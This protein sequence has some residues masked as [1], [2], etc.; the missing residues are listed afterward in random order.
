MIEQHG[1]LN[2]RTG[3]IGSAVSSYFTLIASITVTIV[4]AAH[5]AAAEDPTVPVLPPESNPTPTQPNA[6][7]P[8][9][10]EPII[11]DN[12]DAHQAAERRAALRVE[13]KARLEEAKQAFKRGEYERTQE[14]ARMVLLA[15]PRNVLAAEWL[16]TAQGKLM[17]AD[18]KVTAVASDRRD[19]EAILEV[20][21]HAVRP[22]PRLPTERPHFP[23]RNE[24]KSTARQ[25][26]ISEKLDKPLPL[27]SFTDAPLDYVLDI[28]FKLTDVNIIADPAALQDKKLTIL[29]KD[30]PLKQ[31]L[32]FIVRNNE[33][34][35]YS[36]TEDAVWIT[37]TDEKD[38]KKIMYPRIYPLHF[39]LVSTTEG[40]GS[41]IGSGASSGS[42]GSR[43]ARPAPAVGANAQELSYLETI[44]KWLKDQ[45]KDAQTFPEGSDYLVDRQS[46]Q[47]IVYTTPSGH[48]HINEFLDAFDQPAIQVL[49]KARFLDI[50]AENNKSIGLNLDNLATPL[51]NDKVV[52]PAAD[53]TATPTSLVKNLLDIAGG[54]GIPDVTSKLFTVTGNRNDHKFT[55]TLAA[56]MNNSMTKVLSE[57]QILAINNKE[58]SINITTQFQYVSELRPFTQTLVGT[59]TATST[60]AFE[61]IFADED[62]GFILKV[63]PS[64]GRDLKTINLHLAPLIK[65]FAGTQTVD[66]FKSVPS[67]NTNQSL[68]LPKPIIQQT[69]LDTDVVLEDNGYV[70]I[71]GL[72]RKQ[73]EVKE[74]K[75]PGLHRIPFL[76]HLF[77]TKS[78][79]VEQHNLVIIIEAQI[80][81]TTGRSYV[82][83]PAPDDV[84]IRQGGVIRAPG[85][86]SEL[87]R[88]TSINQALGITGQR[89]QPL[90]PPAEI[91]TPPTKP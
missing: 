68:N 87:N 14:I 81:T 3:R 76:G 21:E 90:G 83:E 52:V 27:V 63:T 26:T 29:V 10:I 23:R 58:A 32:N 62:V 64:I 78:N 61:P 31:V 53:A 74:R 45:V 51:G 73:H 86:T 48:R 54:V 38:L 2:T 36:I 47:L 12:P 41:T 44:L 28:L 33:G 59:G 88:P 1:P 82:T 11:K 35:Q 37:A 43:S 13:I 75:I 8:V 17:D 7:P 4:L 46:N 72:Q 85:Q 19:K 20:D 25:L 22:P 39:G 84:D 5:L 65:D 24:D 91:V 89:A 18:S 40:G 6:E 80:I 79:H 77:K 34:M 55:L 71:G 9:F 70:I 30:I 66:D 16:R 69:E 49:I 60:T 50:S 15:D 42:S 67:N 57:P 56:L